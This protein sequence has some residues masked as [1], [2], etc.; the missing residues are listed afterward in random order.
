M[1]CYG[2]YGYGFTREMVVQIIGAS[3]LIVEA[4]LGLLPKTLRSWDHGSK[5]FIYLSIN[6]LK[7]LR[8]V[9]KGK[10]GAS[11]VHNMK[12]LCIAHI[13][14]LC[15]SFIVETNKGWDWLL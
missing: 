12:I 6:R 3:L 11:L 15:I 2:S 4:W 13:Q 10:R 7:S 14:I 1:D 8:Y 9:E 5:P